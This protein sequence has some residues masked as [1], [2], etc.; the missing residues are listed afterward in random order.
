MWS[1]FTNSIY[2]VYTQMSPIIVY[3]IGLYYTLHLLTNMSKDTTPITNTAFAIVATLSALSFTFARALKG[4]DKE[5]DDICVFAGERF[6]HACLMLITASIIKYFFLS[7]KNFALI[8]R[9]VQLIVALQFIIGLLATLL[10]YF[11][12]HSAHTGLS[13]LNKLLWSRFGR[14][15]E[16]NKLK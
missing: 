3:F 7:V 5:S 9:Y 10:F 15:P 8:S 13:V 1:K 16:W 6:L 14:R 2:F 12:L 11:A 4:S